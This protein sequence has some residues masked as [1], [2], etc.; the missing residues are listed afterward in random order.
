MKYVD[1]DWIAKICAVSIQRLKFSVLG[2]SYFY[3]DKEFLG[4]DE[5]NI[6]GCSYF[7]GF[8]QKAGFPSLF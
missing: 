6:V 4:I 1:V 8:S 7:I 2:F 5:H 3:Q